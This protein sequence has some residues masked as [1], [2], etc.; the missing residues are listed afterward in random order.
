MKLKRTIWILGVVTIGLAALAAADTGRDEAIRAAVTAKLED[1]E[2]T[3]GG[4]PLV[5]AENGV[6]TLTGKVQ[7]LWAKNKAIET[8]LAVDGVSSVEDELEI[9]FGESDKDVAEAVAKTVRR[10]VY[11]TVFDDVNVAVD[12]GQVLLTGRVTMPFKAQE[13]ET[14][15]SKVMGVQ[16]ITNE[17]ETL[18][19]NIGDQRIR[20][21]LAYRIYRDSLFQ[22][23]AF[24]VNPPIHIIVERGSVTLTGAVRSE[25]EKRKAEHIA[26]STF[27]VFK[28]E[29]RLQVAS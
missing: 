4:G 7:N 20:T 21:N 13:I 29:N 28:V 16:A 9:A 15:V 25:V 22:D 8:A 14:R 10:Y 2:I 12:D 11:F 1:A 27:G 24:R 23:Y 18:P 3:N 17:I 5:E 6:V 19:T 26:R